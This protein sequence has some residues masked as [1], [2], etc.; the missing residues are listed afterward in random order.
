MRDF[1]VWLPMMP[2]DDFEFAKAEADDMGDHMMTHMWD[3]E[4]EL[5]NLYA[6]T[7]NLGGTGWDLYLLYS[8]GIRWEGN[9]PPQPTFWMHQLPA[10]R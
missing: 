7:L 9:E 5:G 4:R 1:A 6:N 8:P 10:D 3:P 2:K